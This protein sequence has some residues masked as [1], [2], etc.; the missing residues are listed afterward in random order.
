MELRAVSLGLPPPLAAALSRAVGPSADPFGG[1]A[2]LEAR[3]IRLVTPRAIAD[4]PV[5][6]LRAV[7]HAV[8]LGFAVEP[9]SAAQIE[10]D[11]PLIAHVAG[12]R[13]RDEITRALDTDHGAD[14]VRLMDRL[15]LLG[16]V[17]PELDPARTCD[18]PKEHYWNVFEHSVE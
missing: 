12:E 9:A 13:Q 10:H 4:D 15:G 17:L 14:A 3:A 6:A 1:L 8:E 2:D 16:P 11:A 18:Q 5:R 7:R